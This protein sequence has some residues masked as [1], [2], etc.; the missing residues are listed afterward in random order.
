MCN[1]KPGIG[2]VVQYEQPGGIHIENRAGLE[3]LNAA[4]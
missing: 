4:E 3:E 1:K 2:M